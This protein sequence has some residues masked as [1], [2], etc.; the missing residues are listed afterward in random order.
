MLRPKGHILWL[1]HYPSAIEPRRKEGNTTPSLDALAE[2]L[3]NFVPSGWIKRLP[4]LLEAEGFVCS[5][6][7]IEADR[8]WQRQMMMDMWC[9]I[10][11][12]FA[13]IYL[14]KHGPAGAGDN[15]RKIV[16]GA[17]EEIK[18]GSSYSQVFQIVGA[19]KP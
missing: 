10:A 2:A 14:D 15:M 9:L 17:M 18:Q 1:E 5:W 19:Q 8:D 4:H 16:E 13:D 3:Q 11:N 7:E 6:V 12:E